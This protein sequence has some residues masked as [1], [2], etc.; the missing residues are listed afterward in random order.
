ME[1]GLFLSSSVDCKHIFTEQKATPYL[2]APKSPHASDWLTHMLHLFSECR[3]SSQHRRGP[4]W[5][6]RE[7]ASCKDTLWNANPRASLPPSPGHH[8]PCQVNLP[9]LPL[10][11]CPRLM[12][13][14]Y[15]LLVQMVSHRKG[16]KTPH[17]PL[18]PTL[19]PD[20]APLSHACDLHQHLRL[21]EEKQENPFPGLCWTKENALALA[22]PNPQASGPTS[23]GELNQANTLK[24]KRG[25]IQPKVSGIAELFSQPLR[26]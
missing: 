3:A 7:K 21:T 19:N 20:Q 9:S 16:E 1:F 25:D 11:L 5:D 6:E 12:F 24:T 13:P 8:C 2:G 18:F 17:A 22:S 10:S 23:C 26:K 4:S 14:P 15:F